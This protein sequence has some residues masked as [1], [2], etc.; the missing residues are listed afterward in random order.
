MTQAEEHPQQTSRRARLARARMLVQ[1]VLARP[2]SLVPF[3]IRRVSEARIARSAAALSFSTALAVVPALALILAILAA[4]PVFNE[5]RTTLQQAI[6]A[7]LMPDTGVKISDFMTTFIEATGTLTAFGVI[8][9]VVTAILLLLTIENALNEIL[10][11]TKPRLLRQRLLVFWA[12]MTIGPIL[13]GAGLS[14]FGYFASKRI[15]E[16]AGSEPLPALIL[17]GNLMPTLLTWAT[18]TLLF[19]L[20]PHRRIKIRDALVGAA[21]AAI[22]LAILRYTFALY[23][24]FMT[25]YQAI[26]GALAAVPI[27]LVWIYLVWLAVLSGAVVTGSLPDWRYARSDIGTGMLGRLGLALQILADL[28]HARRIGV[29][30]SAEQLGKNLGAPDTVTTSVLRDLRAGR[31]AAPGD[32]GAWMLSRDLERT[33]LADL[34]HHF[35]L[36]LNFSLPEDESD[37][38]ELGKRV[39]R[40]LRNAAESERALLSIS[41][42]RVVMQAEESK[43]EMKEAIP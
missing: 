28:A 42:A 43:P 39:N 34:V 37:V 5:L 15:V 13:L 6:V 41:L 38:S 9:L 27:F 22:L 20:M 14:S 1:G 25:S 33:T 35:E 32:D 36:G 24:I 3:L 19:M 2:K 30:I 4:F 11:I 23:I 40:H 7:N 21:V 17:V 18:V 8:G 10:K 16:G 31:F 26:Y 12:V 29:G